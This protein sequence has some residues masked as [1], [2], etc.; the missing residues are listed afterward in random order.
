MT[1]K[2]LHLRSSLFIVQFP[3]SYWIWKSNEWKQKSISVQKTMISH[4]FLINFKGFWT[5]LSFL[6]LQ[7]SLEINIFIYGLIMLDFLRLVTNT[8][9]LYFSVFRL[10]QSIKS[11]KKLQFPKCIA[12]KNSHS[13]FQYTQICRVTL[14]KTPI[15]PLRN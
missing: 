11:F 7:G 10:L 1:L 9:N 3:W 15:V 6:K 5:R 14:K 12:E 13:V 2:L 4:S 8:N